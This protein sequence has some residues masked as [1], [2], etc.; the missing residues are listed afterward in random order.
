MKARTNFN[1]A[2]SQTIV[3]GVRETSEK[4]ATQITDNYRCG[5]WHVRNQREASIHRLLELYAQTGTLCFVP[6][7]G[8]VDVA[9]RS[10]CEL[11]VTSHNYGRFFRRTSSQLSVAAS[12]GSSSRRSSSSRCQSGTGTSSG[13]A[14]RLSQISSTRRRRSAGGNFIIWSR[15]A[16]GAIAETCLRALMATRPV[17][18]V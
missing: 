1:R 5:F 4:Q 11:D 14:V 17:R 13:E 6:P 18:E 15:R 10:R 16:S 12:F 3:Q 2:V 9:A 7:N 8:T